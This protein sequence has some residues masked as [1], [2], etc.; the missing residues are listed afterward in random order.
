MMD[1][2]VYSAHYTQVHTTPIHTKEIKQKEKLQ[3]KKIFRTLL[4]P[5]FGLLTG[6]IDGCTNKCQHG[7]R[8]GQG[9]MN[10]VDAI[11]ALE[12]IEIPGCIE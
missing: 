4:F 6:L 2:Y 10:L 8:R 7:I 5:V 3:T 1:C 12:L 11:M 9:P